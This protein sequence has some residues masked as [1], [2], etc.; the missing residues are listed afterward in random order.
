MPDSIEKSG[1]E[2]EPA[3]S[4]EQQL[5][6]EELQLELPDILGPWKEGDIRTQL[7]PDMILRA[8]NCL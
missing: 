8:K 5:S 4:K 3:E 2:F 7:D 1:E 6:I